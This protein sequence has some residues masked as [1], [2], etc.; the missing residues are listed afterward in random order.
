[1]I[2]RMLALGATLI[3]CVSGSFAQQTVHWTYDEADQWGELKDAGGNIVYP[4]CKAAPTRYQSPIDLNQIPATQGNVS[5]T[6]AH[7]FAHSVSEI[8]LVAK[9]NGHTIQIDGPRSGRPFVTLQSYLKVCGPGAPAGCN[10]AYRPT[11]ALFDQVHFHSPA[12][13]R[14]GSSPGNNYPLEGH[15]V[16]ADEAGGLIVL[17]V[18][19][20]DGTIVEGT[21]PPLRGGQENP[22]LKTL[23][24]RLSQL[25]VDPKTFPG[26]TIRLSDLMP[27]ATYRTQDPQ[28]PTVGAWGGF[29]YW[30][31]LT[32]PPCS[33]GV[34]WYVFDTPVTASTAQIAA[35]RNALNRNNRPV[36]ALSGRRVIKN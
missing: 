11:K 29:R 36:Q 13:H 24:N 8:P 12:E 22:A 7:N 15:L 26:E 20:T 17:A 34:D 30:G 9:N 14:Y 4:N 19:F 25:T 5:P 27:P 2:V 10:P 33:G 23:I 35:L 21:K 16:H 6:N 31:S 1:M 32:T 3:L 28:F 18:H